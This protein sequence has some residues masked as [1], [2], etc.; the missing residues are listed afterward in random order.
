MA[1]AE[2]RPEFHGTPGE[3]T[4]AHGNLEERNDEGLPEWEDA[5]IDLGGEG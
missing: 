5:W 2:L 1:Q 3:M 4:R